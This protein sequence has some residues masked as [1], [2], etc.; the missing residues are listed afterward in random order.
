MPKR[1]VYDPKSMTMPERVVLDVRTPND[2][3]EM[4]KIL[5]SRQRDIRH[6]QEAA[7][8]I[9]AGWLHRTVKTAH[10][11]IEGKR[12][13]GQTV[14]AGDAI[15]DYASRF[16]SNHQKVLRA[17]EQGDTD[18]AAYLAFQVGRL[19]EKWRL[20]AQWEPHAVRGKKNG[21]AAATNAANMRAQRQ[22]QGHERKAR[23]A[24]F[25]REKW[26]VNRWL[27]KSDIAK[28]IAEDPELSEGSPMD[29]IRQRLPEPPKRS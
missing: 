8:G 24:A 23:W 1:K 17:I 7:G 10:E 20:K 12:K 22:R 16:L 18:R 15:E 6:D 26:A 28:L 21:E 3:Q 9:Y 29:Y 13:P 19:V 25:A 11:T 14:G 27:S 4:R 5:E 2:I